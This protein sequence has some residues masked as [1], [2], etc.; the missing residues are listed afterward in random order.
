MFYTG[1]DLKHLSRKE[2][3]V[4][5]CKF[6][7]EMSLQDTD[8]MIVFLNETDSDLFVVGTSMILILTDDLVVLSIFHR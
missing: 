3:V 1:D 6:T 7:T 4:L 2:S 8:L 5:P